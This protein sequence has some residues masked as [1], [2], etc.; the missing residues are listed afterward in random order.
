MIQQIFIIFGLGFS[1]QVFCSELEPRTDVVKVRAYP[2]GMDEEDLR[3]QAQIFTPQ[4]RLDAKMVQAKI[5]KT[6]GR[7]EVNEDSS[8]PSNE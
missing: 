6:P 8:D 2:G 7:M 4:R 3:V 5:L 1:V